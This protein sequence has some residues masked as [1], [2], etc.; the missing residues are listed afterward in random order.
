MSESFSSVGSNPVDA[1]RDGGG[2]CLPTWAVR[3]ARPGNV[4]LLATWVAYRYLEPMRLLFAFRTD[5]DDPTV[6]FRYGDNSAC[7]DTQR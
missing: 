6:L 5:G 4:A 3:W 2:G 7:S 1:E